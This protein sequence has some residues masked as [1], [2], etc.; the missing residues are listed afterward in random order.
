QLIEM[1]L[2]VL[3]KVIKANYKDNQVEKLDQIKDELINGF[4]EALNSTRNTEAQPRLLS[5]EQRY[6]VAVKISEYSIGFLKDKLQTVYYE[7]KNSL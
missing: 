3:T 4:I 7:A 6:E 1:Y 5:E 2:K